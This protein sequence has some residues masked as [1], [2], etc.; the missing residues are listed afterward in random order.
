MM[1]VMVRDQSIHLGATNRYTIN[2]GGR[3]ASILLSLSSICLFATSLLMMSQGQGSSALFPM[4]VIVVLSLVFFLHLQFLLQVRR[5]QRRS[6]FDLEMTSG[7]I[8][9]AQEQLSA[10]RAVAQSVSAEAEAIRKTTLTLAETPQLDHVLE[11][12]LQ[13]LADLV[14]Y[15]SATVLLLE[16][17]SRLFVA[18]EKS[19]ASTRARSHDLPLTL[20]SLSFPLLNRILRQPSPVLLSDAVHES[21]WRDFSS[22]SIRSWLGVPLVAADQVLGIL[23]ADHDEA[24]IFTQEHL[25]IATSLAISAVAGIQ[26]ARLHER[27][28]IYGAELERRLFEL[29]NARSALEQAKGQCTDSDERFQIV[30]Q[31]SPIAFSIATLDTGRLVEVNKAFEHRYGYYRSELIGRTVYELGICESAT[32]RELMMSQL[33]QGAPIRNVVTRF[34]TKTGELK[35]T[36]YSADRIS[37]DGKA[38]VFFISG[39]LPQGSSTLIN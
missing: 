38:C 21:Q 25:R 13:S 4:L 31:G 11:V 37:F 15:Q 32:D 39:D 7:E 3:I 24:N 27:A 33:R 36:A 17:E 5:E 8:Q 26:N 1:S 18:N 23:C 35:L 14:P 16:G 2:R 19:R 10:S 29:K 30:F 9:K 20:D 22:S 6:M 12:L 28:D 34:R